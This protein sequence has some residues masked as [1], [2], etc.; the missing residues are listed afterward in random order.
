MDSEEL[1]DVQC[2]TVLQ[3]HSQDVKSVK[4]HPS[5]PIVVSSSYDDTLRVWEES[6]DD[7]ESVA[8]LTGHSSTVWSFSFDASGTRFVSCGDDRTLIVWKHLN[9]L[10]NPAEKKW[11]NVCTIQGHHQ[12]VIYTVDWCPHTDLIACGGAD[13]TIIVFK[14]DE[15]FDSSM[16]E[17]NFSNVCKIESAHAGDVNCVSWNP[18]IVGLLAS[19]GDDD[20]I[21]LWK[22][23]GSEGEI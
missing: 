21:K 3:G 16:R 2:V 9:L 14:Q 17:E 19:A 7:W 22:W 15:E 6:G 23:T 20:K 4:W 1:M 5:L 8:T 11:M 10:N 13:D 18:T 12:R